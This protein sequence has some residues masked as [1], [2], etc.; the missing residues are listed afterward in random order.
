VAHF[1]TS[2]EVQLW[3][4][5]EEIAMHFNGLLM[6]YRLGLIGGAGALASFSTVFGSKVISPKDRNRAR[7]FASLALVVFFA[8]A[9]ALDVFYYNELLQGAVTAIIAFESRHDIK[10]STTIDAET[11]GGKYAVWIVYGVVCAILAAYFLGSLVYWCQ[12]RK[13]EE[14]TSGRGATV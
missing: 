5:Y 4:H 6:Q 2:D 14:I 10:M 12:H 3:Y 11:G 8:A 13:D 9:A 1:P 7:V